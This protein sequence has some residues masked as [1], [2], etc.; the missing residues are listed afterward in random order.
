MNKSNLLA[1][2]ENDLVT[3]ASIYKAWHHIMDRQEE[4]QWEM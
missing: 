2:N 1:E 4:S 3:G